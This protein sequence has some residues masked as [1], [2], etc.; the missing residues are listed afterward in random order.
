MYKT[1]KTI[2][3]ELSRVQATIKK[4][5][6]SEKIIQEIYEY[7]FN[8][9]GK[10]TRALISL[11]ASKSSNVKSTKRIELASVIE[12]LHTATLVHDDVV[13]ES[14]KRRGT[15]SV[16]QVWS[17]SY[18]VLIGDFIYS[19][20][21]ILMVKLNMSA[22]L[23]ELAK[24]TND[25]AKGE[26]IQLELFENKQSIKLKDLLK[27]SYLKTGRLFEAS[28]KTGAMLANISAD[29]IKTF[30]LL[31]K[32]IGIAFQIQDDLLDYEAFKLNTGKPSLKDFREGKIT[33]PLYFAMQNAQPKDK[34]FLLKHL[35]SEK[36][37]QIHQAK[38]YKLIQSE[39]SQKATKTLLKKYINEAHKYLESLKNHACY[40]EML[41]L[42]TVSTTRKI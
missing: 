17:N 21:F 1:N 3:E 18:S 39:A 42:I 30:G 33:F 38:I 13:D 2:Q 24:A 34:E 27:V 7:I 32:A 19:K 25:I 14:E 35:G 41:N 16:N 4:E 10:K 29:E 37:S 6:T 36:I 20:A 12:L 26:I 8:T 15:K 23:D 28:A 22:V 11:L 40:N 31:G 9:E 5:L